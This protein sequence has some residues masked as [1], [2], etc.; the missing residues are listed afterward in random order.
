MPIPLPAKSRYPGEFTRHR[1]GTTDS[2]RPSLSYKYRGMTIHTVTL[3]FWETLNDNENFPDIWRQMLRVLDLTLILSLIAGLLAT[4]MLR[5]L[6]SRRLAGTQQP[7]ERLRCAFNPIAAAALSSICRS[8]D[9]CQIS[10][11]KLKPL[12]QRECDSGVQPRL[13]MVHLSK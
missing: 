3:A 8:D 5:S 4:S 9:D 7:L 6:V 10:R 13:W 12:L 1:I 11:A 2:T